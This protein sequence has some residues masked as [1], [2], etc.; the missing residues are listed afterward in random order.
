MTRQ[1]F[2]D[3][4]VD[5]SDLINFCNDYGLSECEDIY[6]DYDRDEMINERI[7]DWAREESWQE[8]RSVLNRLEEGSGYEYYRYNDDYDEWVGLDDDDFED[9]KND[10]LVYMDDEGLWDEDEEEEGVPYEEEEEDDGEPEEG[11]FSIS[12]L[13]TE[14]RTEVP[15]TEPESES[16]DTSEDD[17][18][19]Q[20]ES[21]S[22]PDD[23]G[24]D[25]VVFD[26]DTIAELMSA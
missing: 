11:E 8:L 21:E 25:D 1:E 26:D 3:D 16:I 13:L 23:D 10:V 14:C 24:F 22:E 9:I 18:A 20:D 4:V 2:I 5:F 12:E 19:S 7:V 15:E 6:D 17:D